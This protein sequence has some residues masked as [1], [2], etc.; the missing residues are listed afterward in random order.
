MRTRTRRPGL[1]DAGC[2][3]LRHDTSTR[4]PPAYSYEE[5]GAKEE[6]YGTHVRRGRHTVA[7][8]THVHHPHPPLLHTHKSP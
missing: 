6:Q 5:G 8:R 2:H 4:R 7:K 1:Q 3:S